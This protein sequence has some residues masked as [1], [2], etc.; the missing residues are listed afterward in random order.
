MVI[1]SVNLFVHFDHLEPSRRSPEEG[2]HG[3][4]ILVTSEHT[5]IQPISAYSPTVEVTKICA[6][7]KLSTYLLWEYVQ[8]S[9]RVTSPFS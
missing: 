2:G 9:F 7:R 8:E 1:P 5:I 6:L 4:M 3:H